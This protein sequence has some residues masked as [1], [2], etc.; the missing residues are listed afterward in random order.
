[1][2]PSVFPDPRLARLT[3]RPPQG[4]GRSAGVASCPK[5]ILA[6]RRTFRFQLI[7]PLAVAG[8]ALLP[9]GL[10]AQGT[11]VQTHTVRKGDTLWDLAQQYLGDPFRWPEIWRRNTETVK[12]PHWIYPDQVLIISGDVAV[13]PGT[14]ADP[15]MPAPAVPAVPVAPADTAEPPAA[16][17]VAAAAE[18]QPVWVQKPMTIFNPARFRVVRGTRESVTLRARESA[19]RAG[20]YLRA[21]FMTDASGIGGTG[22]VEATTSADGIGQT[23]TQRPVQ[24]YDRVHVMLPSG[25][26]GARDDRFV[27]F[28][29]GPT[30]SGRGRV[31]IPTGVVR[32][33]ASADGGRAEALLVTKFEDV[34]VGHH[35]M[36]L[37][38]LPEQP[39]VVPTRVEFGPRTTI[40]WMQDEPII[41]GLGQQLILAAGSADGLVPGDQVTLQR[42]MGSDSRGVALPP[43]D[44]A[45]AQVTRVTRWGASAIVL[46]T[47][48]GGMKTGMDGRVTAK[49]P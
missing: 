23:M 25:V 1:M 34:Y 7:V 49:M 13:T 17:T 38:T 36:V 35:V 26:T 2:G 33:V 4:A 5:P 48:D 29:Y 18:E 19:V 16:D 32:L 14:P 21:P 41:P 46:A 22:R 31:V 20:D 43:E 37:D 44:I 27:T 9:Y 10:A 42:S 15:A 45:V 30:L 8:L 47:T 3:P 12:D 6:M 24:L 40:V 39:G 28:R 11:P